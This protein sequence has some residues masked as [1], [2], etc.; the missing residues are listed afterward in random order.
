MSLKVLLD[1]GEIVLL[2]VDRERFLAHYFGV[3]NS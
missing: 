3:L 1:P 2:A